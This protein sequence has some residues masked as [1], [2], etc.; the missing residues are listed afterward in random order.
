MDGVLDGK[1]TAWRMEATR[2]RHR[3]GARG[4]FRLDVLSR[5]LGFDAGARLGQKKER[6]EGEENEHE[7]AFECRFCGDT[8][9]TLTPM[10]TRGPP[11]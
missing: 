9:F 6:V 2:K 3:T 5:W 10:S 8:E 4:L 7:H 1:L 11:R